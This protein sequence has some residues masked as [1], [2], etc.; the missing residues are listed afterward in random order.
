MRN[1][2]YTQRLGLHPTEAVPVDEDLL[3]RLDQST[4]ELDGSEAYQSLLQQ[5]RE[6]VVPVETNID[7]FPLSIFADMDV[8]NLFEE[9]RE[10][11]SSDEA[12]DSTTPTYRD[13]K[14]IRTNSVISMI[15]TKDVI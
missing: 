5:I 8:E 12:T 7:A 11:L 10:S 4:A 2:R 15:E 14:I 1:R 3:Y 13:R 9:R 6:L